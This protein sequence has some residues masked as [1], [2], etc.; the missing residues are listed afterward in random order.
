MNQTTEPQNP[1]DVSDLLTRAGSTSAAS[2]PPR[3]RRPN[4]TGVPLSVWLTEPLAGCCPVCE[5]PA[6]GAC[7]HRLTH[8]LAP[9]IVEAFTR[10]GGLVYVPEAGNAT[11]L[12]AAVKTGRR[13]VA[14][15]PTR[16]SAHLAYRALHTHASKVASLAILRRRHPGTAP[17]S[18]ASDGTAQLAIAAPHTPTTPAQLA[19]LTTSCARTLKPGG[20]LV[21]TTRQSSGQQTAGH[22]VAHAQAA[23]LFY[24]Q[25]IAAV[26]A[27]A[28]DDRLVPTVTAPVRHRPGCACGH[29]SNSAGRHLLV[30]HDLMVFTKP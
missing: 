19:A 24:L 5:P 25:H 8:T 7:A 3:P 26:E 4:P 9:R 28:L 20:V 30:H 17:T 27:T 15:A 23:G 29:P 1:T 12:I 11:C 13:V 16:H 21:I 10:R 22:L 2:Q 18:P 6:D 14:Y